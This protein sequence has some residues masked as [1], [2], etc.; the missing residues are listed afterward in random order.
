[1]GA[2]GVTVLELHSVGVF[3]AHNVVHIYFPAVEAGWVHVKLNK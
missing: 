3:V 1:M 2:L